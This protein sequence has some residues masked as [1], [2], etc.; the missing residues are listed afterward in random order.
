MK[1]NCLFLL[2][3]ITF[4]CL[5][6]VSESKVKKT[7]KTRVVKANN[8]IYHVPVSTNL[9]QTGKVKL[10]SFKSRVNSQHKSLAKVQKAKAEKKKSKSESESKKS[11]S[12]KS[13]KNK[14]KKNKKSK[15]KSKK[16]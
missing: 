3:V 12:K 1:V 2:F 7:A 6:L 10:Q 5:C 16:N 8:K 4:S 9:L 11:K 15:S 14:A 13:K